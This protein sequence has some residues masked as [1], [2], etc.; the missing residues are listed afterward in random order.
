MLCIS[1][2]ELAMSA[3]DINAEVWEDAFLLFAT[4]SLLAAETNGSVHVKRCQDIVMMLCGLVVTGHVYDC[5]L[6]HSDWRAG[7]CCDLR[8]VARG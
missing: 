6:L 7:R 1:G 8:F 4:V 2:L 5:V 3:K